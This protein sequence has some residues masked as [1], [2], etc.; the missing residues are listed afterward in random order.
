[1]F[2][3][4]K[5]LSSHGVWAMEWMASGLL[6]QTLRRLEAGSARQAREQN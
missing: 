2:K 1:V 3:G 4:V 6:I 5:Q